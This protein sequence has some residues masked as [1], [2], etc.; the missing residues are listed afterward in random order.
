MIHIHVPAGFESSTRPHIV[1]L[2]GEWYCV[3]P[4]TMRPTLEEAQRFGPFLRKLN[5]YVEAQPNSLHYEP[6]GVLQ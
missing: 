1:K 6:H 2:Q 4:P 5:G 3:W